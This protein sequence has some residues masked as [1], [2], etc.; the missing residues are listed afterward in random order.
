[1]A[2]DGT[3]NA[4]AFN[5]TAWSPPTSIDPSTGSNPNVQLLVVSCASSSFCVA[6]DNEGDA[7]TYNGTT[8]SKPISVDVGGHPLDALSCPSVAGCVAVDDEGTAYTLTG[9]SWS[10]VVVDT[11]SVG[12]GVALTSVS[13][14]TLTFCAAVDQNN[15]ALTFNG[16]SWS[17]PQ[18][19]DSLPTKIDHQLDAVSCAS[20]TFCVAVDSDGQDLAY[21]GSTWSAGNDIDGTQELTGVSC[22]TTSFCA[23]VD[24]NGNV[25]DYAPAPAGNAEPYQALTPSRICDTR[26]GGTKVGCV[27]GTTLG[28][29]G[30]L[31][32]TAAGN[33]GVPA[34]GVSAV[35]VN[36]TVTD[37]TAAS[38]LTVFPGG[39]VEPAASSLNWEAGQTVP[40]L[41]TVALSASGTFE[42]ENALGNTDVVVDVEGYYGPQAVGSGLYNALSSPARICDTRAANPSGLSGEPLNQCEGKAP[43][44]GNSLLVQVTGLAGVPS[45]GVG[46]VVLNVTAVSPSAPGYLTVYPAGGGTPSTSN[47]NF[48]TGQV[49][50]NR[51][52]V[53]VGAGSQLG[54]IAVLSS[55]GTPNVLV[56]VAGWFTDGSNPTATGTQFTP[57]VSPARV[58]DTRSS[59][60][61]DTPCTGSTLEAGG[62]LAVSVEGFDGIPSGV[63]AVALNVTATNTSAAGYLSISPTGTSLP[64]V[65]DSNWSAHGTVASLVIATVGSGGQINVTNSAGS[66]DVI[67]DVVGWFS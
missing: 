59:V 30:I 9:T 14:P 28:P 35:V 15:D 57:V 8:W 60:L 39:Q 5:G 13:C 32:V 43:S 55:G 2:V 12:N 24:D 20:S 51:V 10:S 50:A 18:V 31:T 45:S 62:T 16:T 64:T 37:T 6:G 27:S 58:C 1:M 49:V 42:A 17:T 11:D 22:P 34:S 66:T 63:T 4:V 61:Y 65:S 36:V 40:N 23:A 52:I 38:Y 44:A 19:I 33:D 26:S 56:D 47:V 3:G 67:V 46:A 48:S 7:L 54:A 41:V 25:L 29:G 21:S 53:P